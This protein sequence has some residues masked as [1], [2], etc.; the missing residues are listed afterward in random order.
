MVRVTQSSIR[1]VTCTH[2]LS[3]KKDLS[4]LNLTPPATY[5]KFSNKS[6]NT[7]YLSGTFLAC[8]YW[9]RDNSVWSLIIIL[10]FF[11]RQKACTIQYTIQYNTIHTIYICIVQDE[12]N[13]TLTR[14]NNPQKDETS[15]GQ[16]QQYCHDTAKVSDV[17]NYCWLW[18]SEVSSYNLPSLEN[19]N[20]FN[21][22]HTFAIHVNV[23]AGLGLI[24]ILL[25]NASFPK[26]GN[27]TF[28][29]LEFRL[30]QI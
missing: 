21:H 16:G 3:A 27:C 23:P 11:Q 12:T 5:I 2:P 9:S 22:N 26:W 20:Q 13:C 14:H 25:K 30:I 18:S 6:I 8:L 29:I 15:K 19:I 1:L 28:K 10:I 7:I 4:I 24:Y 17:L